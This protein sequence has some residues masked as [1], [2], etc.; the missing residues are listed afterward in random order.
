[1]KDMMILPNADRRLT[2]LLAIAFIVALSCS[3][4]ARANTVYAINTTITSSDPTGNPL[5]S[6]SVV[7]TITTDG[8]IG[9]LGTSNIVSW[10]LDLN[11]LLNS[12]YDYDL[13]PADSTI[14]NDTGGTLTAS[15]TALSYNF[16]ATGGFLIQ[17]DVPGPFSGSSYFCFAD[18]YYACLNGETISPNYIYTDG[19]VATGAAGPTGVVPLTPPT[20]TPV[21]EPSSLMLL[22]T[23]LVGLV[24]TARRKVCLNAGFN[25]SRS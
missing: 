23:G 16:G 17:A 21:P 4:A 14:V 2:R 8:T 15:A 12:A 11:D 6:D 25:R 7:G 22:G 19:V 10:N 20:G 5:Q 18:G 24:E 3:L 1:M 9:A 13:T